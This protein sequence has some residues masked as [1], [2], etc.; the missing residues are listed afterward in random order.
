[1]ALKFQLT[2]RAVEFRATFV[3]NAVSRGFD[4]FLHGVDPFPFSSLPPTQPRPRPCPFLS[5]RF[6]FDTFAFC[7]VNCF[8]IPLTPVV[9]GVAVEQSP[10][11]FV[12]FTTTGTRR[13]VMLFWNRWYGRSM[14]ATLIQRRVMHEQRK[15]ERYS[16][17]NRWGQYVTRAEWKFLGAAVFKSDAMKL[18]IPRRWRQLPKMNVDGS[19][20][21]LTGKIKCLVWIKSLSEM[22]FIGIF[23]EMLSENLF[24][25]IREEYLVWNII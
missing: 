8:E 2:L 7:S 23:I 15:C 11:A 12:S 25:T 24:L 13:A 19:N 21:F 3:V 20:I 17:Y 4:E 18:S 16:R 6:T 22:F 1:M 14:H 9:S 5:R 10:P